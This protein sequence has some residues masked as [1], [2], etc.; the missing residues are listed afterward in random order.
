MV[1]FEQ[2]RGDTTI[3]TNVEFYAGVVLHMAG[4]SSDLFTPSFMV[5]RAI[6]WSAHVLEQLEN[7]KIMRPSARYVGPTPQ[8]R[9]A[10]ER[11]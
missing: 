3:V 6:G 4:L 5:S 7:N 8:R 10:G 9:D 1:D 2:I 11:H